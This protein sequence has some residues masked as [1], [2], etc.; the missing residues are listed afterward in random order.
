MFEITDKARNEL[1]KMFESESAK[2]K[3]L[4]IYFQ[5]FGWSGPSLGMALEESVDG[6]EKM[7]VNSISIYI[8]KQLREFIAQNGKINIDFQEYPSGGGGYLITVGENG[9]HDC[10]GSCWFEKGYLHKKDSKTKIIYSFLVT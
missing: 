8:D 2:S 5:G 9:V 7:E 1:T 4:I 3:N 6:M 10:G